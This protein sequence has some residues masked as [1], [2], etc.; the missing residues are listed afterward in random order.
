MKRQRQNNFKFNPNKH[1]EINTKPSVTVPDDSYTIKDILTRFTRGIDPMLTRMGEYEKEQSSSL[2]EAEFE[3]N[4]I[5]QVED[6]T[7]ISELEYFLKKTEKN[8]EILIERIKEQRELQEKKLK[9]A[10]ELAS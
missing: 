8:K 5:R 2:D 10:K 9:E 6:L 7:D 3:L 4:P 1:G